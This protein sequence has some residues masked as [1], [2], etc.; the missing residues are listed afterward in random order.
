MDDEIIANMRSRVERCRRLA[1]DCTDEQTARTLSLMA[2]EGEQ[3][4]A[5]I[6][7]EREAGSSA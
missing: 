4:I 5:R 3:D 1:R 2:D 7:A 6:L